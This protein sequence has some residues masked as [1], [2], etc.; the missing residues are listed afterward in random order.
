MVQRELRTGFFPASIYSFKANNW[1][2]TTMCEICPK[3]TIIVNVVIDVVL[4]SLLL[5]LSRFHTLFWCSIVN[6]E[7]VDAGWVLS[8]YFLNFHISIQSVF[9]DQ[10]H[11]GTSLLFDR[12]HK[13]LS[14]WERQQKLI[15]FKGSKNGQNTSSG[16]M[17]RFV[18]FGTIYTI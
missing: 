6:Y 11:M 1:N 2:T 18:Q 4:V 17:K 13:V 7:Q 8:S 9:R 15:E 12:K 16:K 10:L 14:N 3:L 5:T